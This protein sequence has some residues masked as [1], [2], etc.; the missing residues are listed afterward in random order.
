MEVDDEFP[1]WRLVL[2]GGVPEEFCLLCAC[3]QADPGRERASES[4]RT[5]PVNFPTIWPASEAT[6]PQPG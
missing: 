1:V 2:G 6:S 3:A 5:R 4:V